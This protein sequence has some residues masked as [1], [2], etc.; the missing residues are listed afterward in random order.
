MISDEASSVAFTAR[1]TG[2]GGRSLLTA[3]EAAAARLLTMN[4]RRLSI[5]F[6]LR[7][8][9]ISRQSCREKYG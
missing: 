3:A 4:L 5:F 8:A 2:T 6:L 9:M 7:L 1:P